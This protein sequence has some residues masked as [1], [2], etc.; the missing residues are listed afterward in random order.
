T[1]V[2]TCAL[3]ICSSACTMPPHLDHLVGPDA[4]LFHS[5]SESLVTGIQHGGCRL[6]A[7]HGVGTVLKQGVLVLALTDDAL[8]FWHR[9]ASF[10]RSQDPVSGRFVNLVSQ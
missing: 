7:G 2:Q 4:L 5:L 10:V 1:G 3:P 8:S 9:F 6:G